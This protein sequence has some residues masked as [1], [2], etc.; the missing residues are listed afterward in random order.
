MLPTYNPQPI[1]PISVSFLIRPVYVSLMIPH[2]FDPA[3]AVFTSSAM[4]Y[5]LKRV[6]TLIFCLG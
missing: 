2:H 5:Y 4:L 6:A 1:I 3:L